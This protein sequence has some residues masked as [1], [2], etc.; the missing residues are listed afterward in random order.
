MP[1]TGHT[2]KLVPPGERLGIK[3]GQVL[4]EVAGGSVSAVMVEA[5]TLESLHL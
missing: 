3:G 1:P 4:S 2:E 5:P